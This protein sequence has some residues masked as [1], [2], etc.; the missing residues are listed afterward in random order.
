MWSEEEPASAR[1]AHRAEEV[2]RRLGSALEGSGVTLTP[3]HGDVT[4]FN[5][6]VGSDGVGLIDLDD[7]R[8]DMPAIDFSQALLELDQF[9]RCGGVA[10]L[11][12]FRARARERLERGY[13]RP[14]PRGPEFW[15]P[16]FRNLSVFIL[17]LARRRSGLGVSRL[18]NAAHYARLVAELERSMDLAS[19][20][21]G[22]P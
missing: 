19:P 18:S 5:I 11:V 20:P 14:I 9:S 10:P 21:D 16:H 1:L 4:S 3:C 6:L 8:F 13:G 12:R 22:R 2:V 15:L 7:F 17:T